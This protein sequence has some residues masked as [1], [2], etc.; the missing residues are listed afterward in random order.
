MLHTLKL[1]DEILSPTIYESTSK[2]YDRIRTADPALALGL[3]RHLEYTDKGHYLDIG[4]GSGNYTLALAGHGIDIEGLDVSPSMLSKARVKDPKRL[5]TLGDMHS[6]PYGTNVFD[7]AITMNT[8]HYVRNTLE[9]VFKEIERVL[10]PNARLVIFIVELQQCMN[11]WVGHYF[12]FFWDVGRKSLS[13]REMTMETLQKA[14]FVDL[15]VEPFFVTENTADLFAHACKYRPHLF[16]DPNIRATMTPFQRPEY[17]EEIEIGCKKLRQ[18]LASGAIYRVIAQY[19][20]GVGEGLF[21]S[22]KKP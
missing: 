6:L 19:E 11:Y 1:M 21:I 9:A 20:T 2:E 7:G 18:D 5:W 8:I 3:I 22:G 4:C 10:K 13:S 15:N 16:L 12:P 17:Q 14:G